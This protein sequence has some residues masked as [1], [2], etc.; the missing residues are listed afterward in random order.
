MDQEPLHQEPQ[1]SSPPG[2]V[3]EPFDMGIVY[4]FVKIMRTIFLGFFVLMVDVFIGL[5]LG[6]AIAETSTRGRMI[7]FYSWF[8]LTLIG[9]IYVIWRMWRVKQPAP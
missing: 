7:F 6:F 4:Y 8:T 9:Y 1:P 5:Y 2:D 3:K